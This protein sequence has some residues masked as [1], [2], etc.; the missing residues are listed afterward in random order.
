MNWF[1][2]V[3]KEVRALLPWWLVVAVS[4]RIAAVVV[5]Q[6][7]YSSAHEA[8]L[9]FIVMTSAIGIIMLGAIAFGDELA[10]GTLPG[11]LAQP[12]RRSHV[13]V[14]KLIPLAIA[15][16]SIGVLVDALIPS[17]FYFGITR[18]AMIW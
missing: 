1:V 2:L 15:V 7:R 5:D 6:Y 4:V 14:L 3:R 9:L 16:G 17:Y 11:L 8:A 10:Y 18:T 13:I 12:V